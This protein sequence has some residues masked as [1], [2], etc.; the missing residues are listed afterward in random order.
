MN[1]QYY[2]EQPLEE[3]Q[4]AMIIIQIPKK[5]T[6]DF[7]MVIIHILALGHFILTLILVPFIT[8]PLTFTLALGHFTRTQCIG[9]KK[10]RAVSSS[11]LFLDI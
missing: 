6:K 5:L 11:F 9:D 1:Y 2:P 3:Y 4:Y 8:T 7:L 10:R